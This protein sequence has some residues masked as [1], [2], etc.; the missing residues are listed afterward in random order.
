MKCF[1][2]SYVSLYIPVCL[3]SIARVYYFHSFSFGPEV[4]AIK[5]RFDFNFGLVCM[6]TNGQEILTG[7]EPPKRSKTPKK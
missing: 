1:L 3:N 5:L 4:K 2:L 6:R 7:F